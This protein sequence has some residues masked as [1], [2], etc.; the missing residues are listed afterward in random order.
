MGARRRTAEG[1]VLVDSRAAV[2]AQDRRPASSGQRQLPVGPAMSPLLCEA[3]DGT[4]MLTKTVTGWDGEDVIV[5]S[6]GIGCEQC[7]ARGARE[8]YVRGDIEV[9]ELERRIEKAQETNA[10]L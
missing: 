9:D 7:T 2:V 1:L 5:R 4:R 3:C 6:M 8:A 10:S